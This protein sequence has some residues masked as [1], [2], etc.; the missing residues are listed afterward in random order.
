MLDWAEGRAPHDY[1]TEISDDGSAW[2]S[3]REVMGSNGGRDYLFL[4]ESES[5]FLRIR[6]LGASTR[7]AL[8]EL[9]V[10]PLAW[11]ASREVFFEAV[12]RDAPRGAY[13]RSFSGEQV[14]WTVVGVDRDREESLRPLLEQPA[15]G[16][17][18]WRLRVGVLEDD[19]FGLD[20]AGVAAGSQCTQS[21]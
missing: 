8:A 2:R 10:E 12:A 6:L 3:L 7:P 18:R 4:P 5:R 13:P 11:S 21:P 14:F 17:G 16:P 20:Q 15:E 9:T 1:V 19:A